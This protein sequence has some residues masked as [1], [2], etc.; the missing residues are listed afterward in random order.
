MIK[1]MNEDEKQVAKE[2]G[3]DFALSLIGDLSYSSLYL[4]VKEDEV[5]IYDEDYDGWGS[6]NKE[7]AIQVVEILTERYKLKENNNE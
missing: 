3:Y 2:M 1:D 5:S 7:T 6:F 4:L